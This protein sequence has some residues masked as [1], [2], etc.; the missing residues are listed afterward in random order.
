MTK[1]DDDSNARPAGISPRMM[2]SRPEPTEFQ[3]F[4]I[5]GV[6][7]VGLAVIGILYALVESLH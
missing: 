6:V 3:M 1:L 2:R 5:A 4:G 7:L